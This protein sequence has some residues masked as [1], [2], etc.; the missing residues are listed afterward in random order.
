MSGKRKVSPPTMLKH[1]KGV[2]PQTVVGVSGKVKISP[3][4]MSKHHR[5]NP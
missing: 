2:T 4:T 5:G 3:P 1:H